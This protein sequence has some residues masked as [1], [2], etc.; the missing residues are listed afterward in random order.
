[1]DGKF[2]GWEQADVPAVTD[3]YEGIRTPRDLYDAL[4]GVW[5]EAGA[6]RTGRLGSVPS[7]RFLRRIFLEEKCTESPGRAETTIA[8]MW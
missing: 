5:C 1:M 6:G 3:E 4:S 7:R 2:Y 8:I